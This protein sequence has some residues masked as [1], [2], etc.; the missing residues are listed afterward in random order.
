M[1]SEKIQTC[2]GTTSIG[3]L[4]LALI[5]IATIFGSCSSDSGDSFKCTTGLVGTTSGIVCGKV[6][7]ADGREVHAFLGIPYAESTAGDNRWRDPIPKAT[8]SGVIQATE[9]GER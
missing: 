5:T 3:F 2:E 1:K 8:A 7:S 9:F 6:V 4:F